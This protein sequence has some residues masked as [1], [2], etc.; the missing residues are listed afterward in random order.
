MS[1]MPAAPTYFVVFCTVAIMVL[2]SVNEEVTEPYMVCG[3]SISAGE[4]LIGRCMVQD[5]P[6]H[7]PQAQAYCNGDYWTWDPKI[8]TPPGL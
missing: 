3:P 1:S 4:G 2:K 5:E 7:V 6:F 8:T